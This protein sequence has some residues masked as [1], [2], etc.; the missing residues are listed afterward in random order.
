MYMLIF[1]LS[2]D[3]SVIIVVMG[4]ANEKGRYYVTLHVIDW[5]HT[6]NDL[7]VWLKYTTC[8]P[9]IFGGF[10]LPAAP[11]RS[12]PLKED[13]V[14]NSLATERY[15][16]NFKSVISKHML[17]IKSKSAPY[18]ISLEWMQIKPQMIHQC[19]FM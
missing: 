14:F 3:V 1:F 16:C 7:Q 13:C 6:Q 8:P 4:L 17:L 19:C 9:A 12:N 11:L 5:S 18:E 15:V 2:K 10:G